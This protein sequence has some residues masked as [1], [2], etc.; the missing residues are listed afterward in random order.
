VSDDSREENPGA[1]HRDRRVEDPEEWM[2]HW[3]EELV[4]LW[5]GLA[6]H[7]DMMG[8]SILDACDFPA[9]AQFCWEHSRGF[10]P[11]V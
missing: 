8:A 11:L 5:H 9:F 4:T 7:R 2:D 6:A 10:P 3:S 1:R